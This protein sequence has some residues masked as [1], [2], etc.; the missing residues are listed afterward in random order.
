MING[1]CPNTAATIFN[2]LRI[3]LRISPAAFSSCP[4]HRWREL[5]TNSTL[6][7]LNTRADRRE[8]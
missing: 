7:I 6:H 4:T 3:L 8:M 2:S 5:G 1:K